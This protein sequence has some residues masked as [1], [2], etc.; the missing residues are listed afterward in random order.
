MKVLG[1][2]EKIDPSVATSCII[3]INHLKLYHPDRH[4]LIEMIEQFRPLEYL[5][6]H[7]KRIH[8]MK[9]LQA[10]IVCQ[11]LK[12][13]IDLEYLD[14]ENVIV[15]DSNRVDDADLLHILNSA[16]PSHLR[17]YGNG[18][19]AVR[20]SG[21]NDTTIVH[22]Q[23]QFVDD[24]PVDLARFLGYEGNPHC[25]APAVLSV[26]HCW[27][28]PDTD[29]ML[30]VGVASAFVLRML[31]YSSLWLVVRDATKRSVR[32]VVQRR[33]AW[34]ADLDVLA[35]VVTASELFDSGLSADAIIFVGDPGDRK[36]A[37][38]YAKRIFWFCD[39]DAETVDC[40]L[41]LGENATEE[42][43]EERTPFALSD[44]RHLLALAYSMQLDSFRSR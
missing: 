5:P 22:E 34:S 41:A 1:D 32:E 20:L 19:G 24:K 7:E 26:V 31:G 33:S 29:V 15:L 13:S 2:L 27:S 11:T 18:P 16:N 8:Y 36:S 42:V 6:T 3:A 21:M 39:K 25:V 37:A 40:V 9:N 14:F 38:T 12:P 17:L 4:D 10:R 43:P 30:E 23:A 28:C 35:S 44:Y